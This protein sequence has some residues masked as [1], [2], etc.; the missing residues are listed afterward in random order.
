VRCCE[1]H[2][3]G[4]GACRER[5]LGRARVARW[6]ALASTQAARALCPRVLALVPAL[7][8][9]LVLV[10]ALALKQI[11]TGAGRCSAR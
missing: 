4:H 8:L 9:V 6:A 11:D 2:C 5:A 7:V 1:G 10:L 3:E